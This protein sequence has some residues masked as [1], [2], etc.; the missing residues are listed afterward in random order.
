MKINLDHPESGELVPRQFTFPDGQPHCEFHVSE[1]ALAAAQGPIDVIASIQS[2][3]DLL[4]IGLVLEALKSVQCE[5]PVRIRLN[6]SYLLGARMD[7]RIAPGSPATLSVIATV[8]NAWSPW[9]DKLTV[10]DAHSPVS[11]QLL[12]R[13]EALLPDAL[14]DFTV[15]A[16]AKTA[17]ASTQ[18]IVLVIPDAGALLR[19]EAMARRLALTHPLARCVKKRDA[20]SGKLSGFELVSGEVAGKTAL[21]VDDICDGG[22]TF[23]GI[24]KALRGAGAKHVVLCVTHGIFSKGLR[25]EGVDSIYCTDSYRSAHIRPTAIVQAG[26]TWTEGENLL[27]VRSGDAVVLTQMQNFVAG[28]L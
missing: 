11:S 14:V 7:R 16:L 12:P 10:L 22:G 20:Q 13:M 28:V 9:L 24:A 1:V 21:I 27:R 8:L 26:F 19:V 23:A 15:K 2:G 5:P 3:N 17:P 25:I 4:Q 6:I 18:S